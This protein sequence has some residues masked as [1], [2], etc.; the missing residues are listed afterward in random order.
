MTIQT[1]VE[2][3]ALDAFRLGLFS[4]GK[5]LAFVPTMGALHDGHVSLVKQARQ[6]ADATITSIFVN[7]SQFAPGEDFNRYPRT[8]TEDVARLVEAGCDAVFLPNVATMY[9]DGFQTWIRNEALENDLCG[10]S[11]PGHFRGVLTIVMKLLN[12]VRPDIAIF[13]KKDYQQ[14]RLI[15]KMA[16]DLNLPVKIVG[17]ETVREAD[18]LAM[19]SRNRYLTSEQ[20]PRAAAIARGLHAAVEKRNAGEADAKVLLNLVAAEIAKVPEMKVEYLEI[21]DQLA[22]TPVVGKI[23]RPSVIMVAAR[24]GDLRLIDNMELA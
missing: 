19:S 17:G 3:A 20:R 1:I 21:R 7:P 16:L 12:L 24:L 11:R 22:L 10:A 6:M 18:G 14:W 4:A 9:P 23:S 2:P 8:L 13:G 15:E 5:K